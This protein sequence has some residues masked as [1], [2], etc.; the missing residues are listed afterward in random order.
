MRKSCDGGEQ[1]FNKRPDRFVFG[2][3][4]ELHRCLGQWQVGHQAPSIGGCIE[5]NIQI[6]G[7]DLQTIATQVRSVEVRTQQTLGCDLG[8]PSG[9][10]DRLP[11]TAGRLDKR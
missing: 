10:G 8:F 2:L 6:R 1:V 9:N 11:G 7:K 3:V 5:A 4:T